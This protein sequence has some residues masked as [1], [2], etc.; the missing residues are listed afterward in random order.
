VPTEKE[1]ESKPPRKR[2][3]M[4]IAPAGLTVVR[5]LAKSE[6]RSLSDMLRLLVMEALAARGLV[7]PPP[8][9]TK[10]KP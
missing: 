1:P 8:K 4:R 6:D 2:V 5:D 10:G 7:P 3:D 9:P